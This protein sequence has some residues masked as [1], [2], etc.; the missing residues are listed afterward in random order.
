MIIITLLGKDEKAN[1]S[2]IDLLKYIGYRKLDLNTLNDIG[3]SEYDETRI[4]NPKYV[5][6]SNVDEYTNLRKTY[7]N[8]VLGIDIYNEYIEINDDNV[9]HIDSSLDKSE[10]LGIIIK[11]TYNIKQKEHCNIE[12]AM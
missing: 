8:S 3:N 4:L 9:I 7:G 1:N 11:E 2:Q 10:I 5:T 6:I 12:Q